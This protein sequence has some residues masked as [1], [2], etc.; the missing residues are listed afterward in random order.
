M[1]GSHVVTLTDP[2]ERLHGHYRTALSSF[3]LVT[4]PA[5]ELF[6]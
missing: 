3:R 5:A 2:L 6:D 1:T 4:G